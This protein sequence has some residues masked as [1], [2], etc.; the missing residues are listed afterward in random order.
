MTSGKEPKL[1]VICEINNFANVVR[2]HYAK[3][4]SWNLRHMDH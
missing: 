2:V 1:K 3:S 4:L